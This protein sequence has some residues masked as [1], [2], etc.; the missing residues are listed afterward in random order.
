MLRLKQNPKNDAIKH[1]WNYLEVFLFYDVF[2]LFDL[3]FEILKLGQ[4]AT[5]TSYIM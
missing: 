2:N 1:L 5:T 3:S 4:L